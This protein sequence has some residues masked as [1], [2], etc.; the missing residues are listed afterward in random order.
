MNSFGGH[1]QTRKPPNQPCRRGVTGLQPCSLSFFLHTG[2]SRHFRQLI[3]FWES[4]GGGLHRQ[5]DG[6][7]FF[8]APLLFSVLPCGIQERGVQVRLMT[9]PAHDYHFEA[10]SD[11]RMSPPPLFTFDFTFDFTF[12]FLSFS[13]FFLQPFSFSV[14]YSPKFCNNKAHKHKQPRIL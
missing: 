11:S 3:F 7:L 5:P 13:F 10:I 2:A 8:S 14:I 1:K 12:L 4:L 6:S 9:S